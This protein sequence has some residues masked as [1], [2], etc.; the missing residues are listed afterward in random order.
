MRPFADRLA[1]AIRAKRSAACVGLDPDPALIP[2]VLFRGTGRSEPA[3]TL[4]AIAR[5]NAVVLDIAASRVPCVKP[6]VAFYER[7][8]PAGLAVFAATLSRARELGL[9]AIADV[10][11]GDVPGTA[12]AYAAAYF[13]G[14]G[15]GFPCDAV[16]LSP[17]LGSDS[18]EP[19]LEAAAKAGG[20][21]FFLV[22]T[23]NP[24]ARE[25]QDL[26][27][28]RSRFYL[29]TA[30]L[31]RSWSE[32]LRGRCGYSG[33]GAVVGATYPAE[34]RLLRK[35][36]PHSF[37]LLPGLGS[38]GGKASDLAPVFDERGLGALVSASRS[39]IFPWHSSPYRERFGAPRWERAIEAAIDDMNA[40]IEA[41]R[42]AR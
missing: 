9:L 40:A 11:R 15:L 26:R 19:W 39:A 4:G 34:A 29:E 37:F 41:V 20:G 27:C 33:V 1:A 31:V 6:Q 30:R 28:G 36:L 5:F 25:L 18:V 23:S 16:T 38:Q 14:D 32:R 7:W 17:Y 2:R 12:K 35:R 22:R 3:R 13:A 21:M 42:R 24:G 8:G 10:K